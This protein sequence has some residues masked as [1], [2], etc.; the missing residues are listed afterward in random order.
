MDKCTIAWITIIVFPSREYDSWKLELD[1]SIILD[2]LQSGK[3]AARL[4][5]GANGIY[6][7]TPIYTYM[8]V[9]DLC[10]VPPSQH[11]HCPIAT[12]PLHAFMAS[13]NYG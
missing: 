7:A 9:A 11:L 8:Y 12:E 13:A 5:E 6:K 4:M 10:K 3:Y 1:V 2:S